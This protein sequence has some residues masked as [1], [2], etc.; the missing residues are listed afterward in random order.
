MIFA[1]GNGPLV[2][3]YRSITK[4][5]NTEINVQTKVIHPKYSKLFKEDAR[6]SHLGTSESGIAHLR[7]RRAFELRVADR[8]HLQQAA[9]SRQ[10]AVRFDSVNGQGYIDN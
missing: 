4:R 1:V 9:G 7:E 2:V 3:V 8:R 10:Q 5:Q 6:H